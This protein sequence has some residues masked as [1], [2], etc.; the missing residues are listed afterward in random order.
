MRK[1]EEEQGTKIVHS[2]LGILLGGVVGFLVCVALLA[3]FSLLIARGLL[4]ED[5]MYRMAVAGCFVGALAGGT[6]SV[7]RAKGKRLF[8]GMAAGAA[9]FLL[10]L[11]L[12][13]FLYS[14]FNPSDGG[15]GLLIASLAGG[16]A[17]GIL[18]SRSRKKRR[19]S[20]K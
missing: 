18:G 10:I 16:A 4:D 7:R 20:L 19:K 3:V 14:G 17:A 8:M 6:V 1:S 11:I 13:A 9:M 15:L 12:G 5:L 2:M